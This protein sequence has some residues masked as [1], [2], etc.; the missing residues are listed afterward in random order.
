[1]QGRT[2]LAVRAP[3]FAVTLAGHGVAGVIFFLTFPAPSL[4]GIWLP[5]FYLLLA[6][7]TALL[8]LVP[9]LSG[10]TRRLVALSGVMLL[11]IVLGIPQGPDLA[12]E[13]VLGT[14]FIFVVMTEVE[15]G[16][17][18]LLCVACALSLSWSQWP[19]TAWGNQIAGASP[20]SAAL[21]GVYFLFLTWLAGLVGSRGQKIRHQDEELERID[22]SVRAL[23]EANLDFQDLATRVQ[24]ETEE[25]E[26]RRITR[27]V[28]DIVGYTLTNIQMMMEAA[29]DLARRDTAGLEEL[30]VKSRDQ[31]QRGL[32]ETRRAMRNFRA[33]TPGGGLGRVAEVV[34]IFERA[35]K[36]AVKLRLG[37]APQSFGG[38][39]DDVVYRMVQE[40]LTNALRHGNATEITVNFWV[41]DGALRLSITDNGAGSGEI[42]PG[43]G[44]S[45]MAERIS[46]VGGSMKAENTPFGF[47]VSGDIPLARPEGA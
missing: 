10:S 31:A 37:N 5:Q 25:E 29:T 16:L 15:G 2:S 43:I 7:A 40:S 18:Y 20:V 36:V 32:L 34:R 45:G 44:L 38:T 13:A 28:H 9:G 22:R 8:L 24:R 47:V 26:R 14:V 3:S 1:M 33:V 6:L 42:V 21:L 17:A 41:M 39:I 27:E 12:L 23:S 46:H 30:L 11:E 35:T 19:I 4:R